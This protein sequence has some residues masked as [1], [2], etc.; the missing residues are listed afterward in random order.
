MSKPSSN[1]PGLPRA[2]EPRLARVG[3]AVARRGSSGVEFR[4]RRP[5]RRGFWRT[6]WCF[7]IRSVPAR[8]PCDIPSWI[9]RSPHAR[10]TGES[11]I[12]TIQSEIWLDLQFA[13][14]GLTFLQCRSWESSVWAWCSGFDEK[15][16]A[17]CHLT[18]L[19]EDDAV[20]VLGDCVDPFNVAVQQ[21]ISLRGLGTALS[22]VSRVGGPNS[23][24]TPKGSESRGS[25]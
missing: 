14:L 1:C 4:N 11:R 23:V 2:P 17:H 21:H 8:W 20:E 10:S 19:M 25:P 7:S 22:V 12:T 18:D 9:S 16:R 15:C 5:R 13:T 3:V 24:T 6:R